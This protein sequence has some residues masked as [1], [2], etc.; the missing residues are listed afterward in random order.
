MTCAGLVHCKLATTNGFL[1]FGRGK[2]CVF[3]ILL[4]TG[5]ALTAARTLGCYWDPFSA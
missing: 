5:A 4:A 2:V 1:V 3:T